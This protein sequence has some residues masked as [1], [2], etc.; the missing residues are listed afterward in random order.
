MVD[1][2]PPVPESVPL[3]IDLKTGSY[4]RPE[5]DGVAP[6]GGHFD[7]DDPDRN[8]DAYD[9][10]MDTEFAVRAVEHAAAYTEYFGLD[11]RIKRGWPGCTRSRPPPPGR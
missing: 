3:T 2:S 11:T 9:E 5:R 8:P 4:F 6:V 10:E 1:P 7:E